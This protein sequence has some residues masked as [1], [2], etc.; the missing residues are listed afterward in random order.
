M[1]P[2]E[3][4]KSGF[5]LLNFRVWTTHAYYLTWLKSAC[6]I[7]QDGIDKVIMTEPPLQET[8]PKLHSTLKANTAHGGIMWHGL[9]S[10][11]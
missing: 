3:N 5:I 6:R 11:W 9:Q 1:A 4:L 7:E 2:L 10:P 8:D